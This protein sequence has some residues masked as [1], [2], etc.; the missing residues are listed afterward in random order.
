MGKCVMPKERSSG[1]PREGL[2]PA[3]RLFIVAALV[4]AVGLALYLKGGQPR[5]KADSEGPPAP[6]TAAASVTEAAAV[7]PAESVP[8]KTALPR[9]VDLGAKKC[10]P[11]KMMAP[12]LDKLKSEFAGRLTV[13]FID[14]WENP[15]AGQEYNVE[16]IPTQIFYDAEG[17][18]L[19]RHQGFFSREDI[20]AKWKELGV[21]L[22]DAASSAPTF[23]R[24]EPA[25]PDM[26]PAEKVCYMCDG[27]IDPRTQVTLATEKGD[28]HLCSPHCFFITYTSLEEKDGVEEKVSVTDWSTGQ[29]LAAVE[30]LYVVGAEPSGRPSVKAFASEAAATA[31]RQAAGGNV[32]NWSGLQAKELANRCGFC[33][34]AVYPEDA[35]EVI[36]EGLRTWGCCTMCALGVAARLQKDIE[37][38]AKDA[39]TGAPIKVVTFE[40]KVALLEPSSALAWAGSKMG[41]EGKPVSTGCFKQAFFTS[42]DNLKKWVEQHPTATGRAITIAQALADKMKLSPEQISKACKIGECAPKK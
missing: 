27:D 30:A 13:E 32:L 16:I 26:R 7:I 6:V 38:H 15:G 10:I 33:D 23:S 31:E 34:R 36:V 20:L 8:K 1:V 40:G 19:F 12:I 25:Q 2:G 3:A 11:C 28:V 22:S 24:M 21:D 42:E 41:P 18:E 14:V 9:L 35:A 17:K 37:V 39:L 29:P 5:V 4:V